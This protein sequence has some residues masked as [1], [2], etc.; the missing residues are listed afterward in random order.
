MAYYDTLP[1]SPRDPKVGPR[2]KQRNKKKVGAHSLTHNISKVGRR[3]GA[4]RWD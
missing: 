2:L 1:N 4:P 3:N